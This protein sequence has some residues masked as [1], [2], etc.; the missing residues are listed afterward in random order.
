[1]IKQTK[2]TT[3]RRLALA[4]ASSSFALALSLSPASSLES[5]WAETE[6]G[7][8]RLVI[9][10]TPREDGTIAGF[11]D[12]ALDP[13]W[14]TYWRDPGSAGIPPLLDFSQSRGI[15]FEEMAYPPPVR[16]DDGYAIWSGY[17]APV[18]FPLTFRRT[19][20]GE[21]EIRA[22]A[23]I[24][25]CDKI[26]VPFQAE[27]AIDVPEEL[28]GQ[29]AAKPMVDQAFA[30]LSGKPAA[31]FNLG[32]V[33]INTDD[34]LLEITAALP[35]FRPS[36]V[37]PEV[38]VAGPEG[39]AFATPVLTSDDGENVR[40]SVRTENLP[41]LASGKTAIP[42]DIVITLGQRAIEQRVEVEIAPS[43]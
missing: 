29:D 30:L 43:K 26:C 27:L 41:E 36:G 32:A 31:D 4:I 24:G 10:P 35:V 11:L 21:A 19:A 20:S 23:F 1:M 9:D 14:K 13:G 33:T 18:Q 7:R 38:F 12:I 37:K 5:G 28:I 22:L 16:V 6:G 2:F 17:T 15:A 3:L 34:K 40:W 25:I 8:M 39:V 42:L